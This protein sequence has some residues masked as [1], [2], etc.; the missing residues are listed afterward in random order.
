MSKGEK[1]LSEMK[2]KR[3]PLSKGIITYHLRSIITSFYFLSDDDKME[4]LEKVNVIVRDMKDHAEMLEF[5]KN[6]ETDD[7]RLESQDWLTSSS[8]LA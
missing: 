1:R 8:Q 5:V 7:E 6:H 2:P 3:I 4:I